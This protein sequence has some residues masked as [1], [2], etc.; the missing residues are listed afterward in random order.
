MLVLDDDAAY[1]RAWAYKDHGKS[2]AKVD[3]PSS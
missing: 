2:L 3:D 1:D